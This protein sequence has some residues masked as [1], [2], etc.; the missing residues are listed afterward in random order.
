LEISPEWYPML[1]TDQSNMY[2]WI[3]HH[4]QEIPHWHIINYLA[5]L[6]DSFQAIATCQLRRCLLD[7]RISDCPIAAEFL[8]YETAETWSNPQWCRTNVSIRCLKMPLVSVHMHVSTCSRRMRRSINHVALRACRAGNS[9][10]ASRRHDFQGS[11][12]S[13]L[14]TGQTGSIN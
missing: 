11:V 9:C 4:G 5:S 12:S 14:I 10:P 3:S 8:Q 6:A 7:S 13:F 1:N 2:L